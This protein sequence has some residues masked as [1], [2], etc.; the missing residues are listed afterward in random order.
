VALGVIVPAL[1]VGSSAGA[2]GPSAR[3][4]V[5]RIASTF[6]A[7]LD[8]ESS[9]TDRSLENEE[10]IA[11]LTKSPVVG[12]GV[13]KPY[14]ARR[15][16][17]N[18]QRQTLEFHERPYSH[19]SYLDAYLHLGLVGVVAIAVL[20]WGL[21]TNVIAALRTAELDNAVRV[22][23]AGAAALAMAVKAA[24]LPMLTYRPAIIALAVAITLTMPSSSTGDPDLPLTAG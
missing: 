7:D 10:A 18:R 22:M 16:T 20:G 21:V 8:Q 4:V 6:S 1:W 24:F 2:L 17:Y 12:V 5:R 11:A 23:G 9:Y 3:E 19:N 13:G 14:G 15:P